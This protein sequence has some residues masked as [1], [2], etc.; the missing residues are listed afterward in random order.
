MK[1]S[2]A[3]LL[4][5]IMEQNAIH[6]CLLGL[7]E[8][9]SCRAIVSRGK[10]H[11]DDVAEAYLRDVILSSLSREELPR[12]LSRRLLGRIEAHQIGLALSIVLLAQI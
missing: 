5:C 4:E 11:S 2:L 10:R 6:I 9:S 1:L 3:Q 8:A 12:L 7:I